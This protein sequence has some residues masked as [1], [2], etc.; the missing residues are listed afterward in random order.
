[1]KKGFNQK[2]KII[3]RTIPRPTLILKHFLFLMRRKRQFCLVVSCTLKED[4][5][6]FQIEIGKIFYWSTLHE[7]WKIIIVYAQ[8]DEIWQTQSN[9]VKR[10][11]FYDRKAIIEKCLRNYIVFA[12]MISI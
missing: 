6:G 3:W 11:Q 10:I 12:L 8:Y 2:V 9:D 7:E 5:Y 4:M 1:M